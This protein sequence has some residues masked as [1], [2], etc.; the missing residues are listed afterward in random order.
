MNSDIA[1]GLFSVIFSIVYTAAAW[2]LPN[3]S[4]GDPMAPKYF[5]L[6][7]GALATVLSAALIYRGTRKK[8]AEKKGK[9]PDT[10]HWVL[11]GGLIIC[12]LGYAVLLERIGFLASTVLFLGAML[13]LV[14]GVKGWKA[15]VL[16][17]IGFSVGIWY[18]FEKL[19]QI[20]LP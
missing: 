4:I 19:F 13:F 15:N 5:P 12:C 9:A 16:T 3:A 7:I 2:M 6:V 10:N 14:N 20:S 8:E 18:V 1:V 17:A 11:I